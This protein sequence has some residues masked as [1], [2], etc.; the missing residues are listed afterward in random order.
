MV[1][2]GLVFFESCI[3]LSYL[4]VT[5]KDCKKYVGLLL[6][7]LEKNYSA[8]CSPSFT[9]SNVSHEYNLTKNQTKNK[10]EN[11]MLTKCHWRRLKHIIQTFHL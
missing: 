9:I 3:L 11:S 2:T 10:P 6:V 5:Q 4:I 7:P 1:F 8:K